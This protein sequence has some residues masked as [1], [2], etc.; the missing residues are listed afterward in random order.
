MQLPFRSNNPQASLAKA[1]A[2]LLATEQRIAV[3]QAD[4]QET[5][6]ASDM[7]VGAV[8]LIDS[9][10]AVERSALQVHKDRCAVLRQAV[11]EQEH[12]RLEQARQAAIADLEK[13][14]AKEVERFKRIEQLVKDLGNEWNEA[15]N[16]RGRMFA[17]WRPELPLPK[18]DDLYDIR[19][20]RRE[21]A[22]SLYSAGR[23]SWNRECSL[24]NPASPIA[25]EGVSPVGLANY[26]ANAIAAVIARIKG[27][28]VQ[29][30]NEE[31]QA[32]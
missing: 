29:L 13:V 17:N 26:A 8:Q 20:L 1:E 2:A 14:G 22:T 25:V 27:T 10:L 24:P 3:L 28:P 6:R 32:A 19:G 18:A 23:P 4:R 15:I 30:N 21:L 16:F 11:R 9:K 7:D 31:D 5:L 12:A